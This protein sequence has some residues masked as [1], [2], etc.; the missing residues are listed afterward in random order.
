LSLDGRCCCSAPCPATCLTV[1]IQTSLYQWRAASCGGIARQ[2]PGPTTKQGGCHHT[3]IASK[4]LYADFPVPSRQT[5]RRHSALFFQTVGAERMPPVSNI[6]TSPCVP[7]EHKRTFGNRSHCPEG[8]SD[9]R[10]VINRPGHQ[11]VARMNKVIEK[12]RITLGIQSFLPLLT[13]PNPLSSLLLPPPPSKLISRIGFLKG[14]A[15]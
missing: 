4:Q 15:S 1:P 13:S 12:R 9:N 11:V 14:P 7:P 5:S 3:A 10:L 8:P 2:S 6:P